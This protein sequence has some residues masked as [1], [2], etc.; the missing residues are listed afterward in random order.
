MKT[1]NPKIEDEYTTDCPCWN[2]HEFYCNQTG[3]SCP[4]EDSGYIP[5]DCP[6]RGEGILIQVKE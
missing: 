4:D 5:T 3:R 6:A 1:Y 2:G